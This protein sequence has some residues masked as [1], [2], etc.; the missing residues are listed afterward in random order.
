MRRFLALLLVVLH[1]ASLGHL[2]LERHEVCPEHGELVHADRAG[3]P[4]VRSADDAAGDGSGPAVRADASDAVGHDDDHCAAVATRR[5][6]AVLPA[7]GSG[8]IILAAAESPAVPASAEAQHEARARYDI[9]P[10]QSP[11]A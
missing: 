4:H 7:D 6:L 9:A 1:A 8:L 3:R 2:L 11:P 5:E 10:K